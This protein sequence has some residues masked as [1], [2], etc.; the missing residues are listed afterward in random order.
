MQYN[1]IKICGMREA[2]NIRA[3]EALNPDWMGF[4]CWPRSSRHVE[5]PPGYL[6]SV[7]RVGVFVN[8]ELSY[9][10]Q[11]VEQLG[12]TRIQLHGDET[13]D[14]CRMVHAAT[15]LP[16]IKA[17][18]ILQAS[19]IERAEPYQGSVDYL[20]FDTKCTCVGGSGQQFD[21]DVLRAYDGSTPFLLS[22]GIGPGDE[23]RLAAFHHPACIGIDVNSRFEDAPALKNV[24]KLADFLESLI[25]PTKETCS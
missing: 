5:E 22:G 17:I 3:V 25:P 12:L 24:D 4:I 15:H 14:F 7:E 13:V 16:I 1:I 8:P 18:S 11:K 2:D 10:L 20:L 21:W 23:Q 9:I 19:D 6:P